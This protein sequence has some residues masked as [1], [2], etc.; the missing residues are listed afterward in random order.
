MLRRTTHRGIGR[1][2]GPRRALTGRAPAKA[3]LAA[4]LLSTAVIAGCGGSGAPVKVGAGTYVT[5]VC[6]A[7]ATWLQDIQASSQRT[8]SQVGGGATPAVA[9]HALE[10]MV[11]ETV[12]GSNR[13]LASL[14][15][16]GVPDVPGGPTIA[17]GL[18]DT[19]QRAAAELSTLRSQVSGLPTTGTAFREAA[20]RLGSSL[21]GSLTGI[22][23]G[24]RGL[25]SPGLERAAGQSTA[26]RS[27]GAAAR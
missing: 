20:T 22:D 10:G 8:S 24:L 1:D 23:A 9:K 15:A 27:L 21:N 3:R 7:V 6:T 5:R 25:H 12:G 16:A 18:T 2:G 14:H 13:V 19:F 26:C 4:L 11:D 17:A